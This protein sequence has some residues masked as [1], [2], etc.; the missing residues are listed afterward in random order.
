MVDFL[1]IVKKIKDPSNALDTDDANSWTK[2]PRDWQALLLAAKAGPGVAPLVQHA[3][4]TGHP[5][6]TPQVPQ[7]HVP[8]IQELEAA[9]N[10]FIYDVPDASKEF[11]NKKW[12]Y[13]PKANATASGDYV[14]WPQHASGKA[15][16]TNAQQDVTAMEGFL[17]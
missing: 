14:A 16:F 13:V 2:V 7:P 17:K 11:T 12:L 6:P 4:N 3:A 9:K 8:T 15:H 10:M 5:V 1:P